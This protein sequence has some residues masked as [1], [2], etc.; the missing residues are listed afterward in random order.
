MMSNSYTID[1][2]ISGYYEKQFSQTYEVSMPRLSVRHK[3]RMKR[4]FKLFAKNRVS[5]KNYVSYAQNYNRNTHKISL[6]KRIILAILIIAFLVVATGF[7]VIYFSDAFTGVVY[8]DNTHLLVVNTDDCP[9]TI[10]KVYKLSVVP[11][12]YELYETS[13]TS[14]SSTVIYK[15]PITEESLIFDQTVKS[16]FNPHINTEGYTLQETNINGCNAVCIEYK[17]EEGVSSVVVWDNGDYVLEL[18]GNFNKDELINLA[19]INEING[20]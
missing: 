8:H 16:E 20:F 14:V 2:I 6:H 4:I 1:E 19:N 3:R 15:N 12:G 10:E 18:E 7:V 17:I 13:K 5:S 9:S 11:E